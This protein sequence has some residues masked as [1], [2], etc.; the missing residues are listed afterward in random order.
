[1]QT[2]APQ[3]PKFNLCLQGNPDAYRKKLVKKI[4]EHHIG[5][6]LDPTNVPDHLA[7]SQGD[8]HNSSLGQGEG[9]A[10]QW[11]SLPYAI[12]YFFRNFSDMNQLMSKR[13]NLRFILSEIVKNWFWIKTVLS[14]QKITTNIRIIK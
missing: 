10:Q 12:C 13:R 2:A 3:T 7:L 9:P 1:M 5:S 14:Y 11:F 6:I 4:K 8:A